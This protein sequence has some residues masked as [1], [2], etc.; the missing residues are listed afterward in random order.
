LHPTQAAKLGQ[1]ACPNAS[2]VC[3]PDE[4]LAGNQAQP[5]RSIENTEGRCAP[6]CIPEVALQHAAIPQGTCAASSRCAPCYHP[7][8]GELTGICNLAGDSP[9]EPAYIFPRCG[10]GRGGCV[11]ENLVPQDRIS[12]VPRDTC[13][14]GRLCAPIEAIKNPN[15]KFPPCTSTVVACNCPG[16]CVP[17]YVANAQAGGNLLLKDNCQNPDDR[18]APCVNPLTMMPTGACNT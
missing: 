4:F 1:D 6:M 16:V 13:A 3:A 10:N 9:K 17:S 18:C 5:C 15:V 12:Q 8:D 11:P 14:V 7:A 2:Y